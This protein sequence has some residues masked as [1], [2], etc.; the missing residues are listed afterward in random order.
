MIRSKRLR[1]HA[2]H[3]REEW[4]K[5]YYAHQKYWQRRRLLAL[6][7]VWDGMSLAEV[8]R[9]QHIRPGTLSEWLNN[10]LHGG[11]EALLSR[12][13]THRS[14]LL[15]PQKQRVVRYIL[16]HKYPVD[17]GI[18]SYQWTAGAMK[19]VIYQKWNITISTARL[20]QLFDEWGLSFQ[21]VH[22]DYGPTDARKQAEFI[23]ELKKNTEALDEHSALI[24]FDEFALQNVPYT[25]YAWAEK[26]TKP[27]IKSDEQHREK[28]NGF[29]AVDVTRGDT[30]VAFNKQSTTAEVVFVIV[31]IILIYMQKGFTTLTILLD[32]AKTHGMK[33]EAEVQKLLAEI[34]LQH[35]LPSVTLRFWHTPSY[36]PKLN[37]AEYI[38]HEVRRK[39]LYNVPC[40]L[41]VQQKAERIKTQLARD[42][43]LKAQQMHNL[44]SFI[45]RQN[46]RRF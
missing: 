43:P 8:S 34:A 40:S 24:A 13:K 29:L 18:D 26:N 15:S 9:Q 11:F 42:A 33:M 3:D 45:L 41:S 16:L 39:G 2:P 19:E 38:I 31:F 25:H 17:Y 6:K 35:T 1:E 36:S 27:R 12:Q 28:L 37:P 20:Y 44:V 10:Y 46:V 30:H 21:K 5:H 23:A 14:Q 4:K 7:A 22:R 32:N